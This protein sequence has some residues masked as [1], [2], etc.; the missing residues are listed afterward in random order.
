MAEFSKLVKHSNES[1]GMNL[2]PYLP[3]NADPTA[4]SQYNAA[5]ISG[6][7]FGIFMALLALYSIWQY[8]RQ[9]S[10]RFCSAISRRSRTG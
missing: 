9:Y 4:G 6:I 2:L 1:A 7:V 5:T 10:G 3:T 8:S